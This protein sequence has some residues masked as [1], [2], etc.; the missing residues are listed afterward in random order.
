MNRYEFEA[1]KAELARNIL[2]T[3]NEEVI[4][5]VRRSY[6]QAMSQQSHSACRYSLDEVKERLRTIEADAIAGRGLTT[7]EVMKQCDEWL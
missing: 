5:A 2:N 4:D 3:D 6:R 1:A 7:E